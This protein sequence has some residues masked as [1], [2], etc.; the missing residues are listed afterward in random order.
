MKINENSE[1]E[2]S[3]NF[4]FEACSVYV[5]LK[6]L[7]KLFLTNYKLPKILSEIII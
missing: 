2:G 3:I 7:F 1:S 4:D 5:K 6:I